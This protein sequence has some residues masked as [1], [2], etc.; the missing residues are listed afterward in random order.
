MKRRSVIIVAVMAALC[1]AGAWAF[2][3]RPVPADS[4]TT[5]DGKEIR[6][7]VVE[8]YNDRLVLSTADGEVTVMKSDIK[9]LNFDSEEDN[10]VRLAQQAF[11][12][13]DEARAYSYYERA[14]KINPDSR[15]AK[16]GL[17]YLRGYAL[18]QS[19]AKKEDAILRQEAI[20]RSGGPGTAAQGPGEDMAG[21][22]SR[23]AGLTIAIRD[24]VPGVESVSAGSPAAD[25]GVR[26]TDRIVAIWGK[27]TG[28]MSLDEILTALLKRS[29]LEMRLTIERQIA[30][31]INPG[32]RMMAGADALIGAALGMELDGMTVEEV[33]E[34]ASGLEKGDLVVAIDGQST[35][36]LALNKAID[37]IKNSK[38][39]TVALTIRRNIIVWR[40]GEV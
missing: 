24:N 26:R 37:L 39:G 40:R 1:I 6:G 17:V 29:S 22:L 15:A 25:A 18:R 34:S 23:T 13:R 16:D 31:Q 27:L 38:S 19:E 14:L 30:I 10:L 36:Y 33:R 7:I 32:N 35:R 20:E 11:E 28:Y 4:V 21:T 8:E 2:F 3:T 5:T 9:E 12:R